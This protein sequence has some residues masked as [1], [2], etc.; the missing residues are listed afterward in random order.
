VGLAVAYAALLVPAQLAALREPTGPVVRRAVG[1]G[2]Q[3]LVPLQAA[4]LARAGAYARAG[5][6]LAS[7]PVGRALVRRVVAT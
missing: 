3:A 5:A 2:I 4:L 7:A 1:A 6:L